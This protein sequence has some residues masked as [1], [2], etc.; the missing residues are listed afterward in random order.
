L[1]VLRSGSVAVFRTRA[2]RDLSLRV[3]PGVPAGWWFDYRFGAVLFGSV[4]FGLR[5]TTT[6]CLVPPAVIVF[7]LARVLRGFLRGTFQS[8]NT[9][10]RGYDRSR[11][12]AGRMNAA[13]RRCHCS[14]TPPPR[15]GYHLAVRRNGASGIP[16]HHDVAN[17][18]L[19]AVPSGLL[20][21]LCAGICSNM[22]AGLP[23]RS[24]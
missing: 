19:A 15:T 24:Y 3:L 23:Q 20:P 5:T 1:W 18:L 9:H 13:V 2:G 17:Y 21:V 14:C 6:G 16:H 10:A 7:A 12:Y 22:Y 11:P 8:A 4:L